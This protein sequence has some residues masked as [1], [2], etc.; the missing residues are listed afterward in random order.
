M[1]E[2][3]SE[4]IKRWTGKRESALVIEIILGRTT[5]AEAGRTYDLT[6]S[7]GQSWV[8]DAK[9]G[10]VDALKANPLDVRPALRD[11]SSRIFSRPTVKQC[12]SSEREKAT[13]PARAGLRLVAPS[14]RATMAQGK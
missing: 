10:M 12:W 11:A 5:M 7:E 3:R 13:S 2:I 8:E 1:S 14:V 4:D 9:T 6:P